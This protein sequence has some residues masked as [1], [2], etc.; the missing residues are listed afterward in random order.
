MSRK[1]ESIFKRSDGRYEGR[2]IKA[3]NNG[4]AVYGYVY[5][6]TYSEC[7]R[8]KNRLLEENKIIKPIQVNKIKGYKTLNDL[9]IKWLSSKNNI[10]QSSYT[11]YYNLINQH[12]KYDIGN[13][14]INKINSEVIN[15]Y[16]QSKL[17]NG[18]IDNAG[19][20]SRNTVYDICNILKQ[21]FKENNIQIDM[22][23]VSKKV[24]TGKSLYQNE[25]ELLID[26]LENIDNS[27]TIGILLSILLGIRESEVCGIR[28]E[29]IDI[30]NKVI[31]INRIVSRVKTFESKRKTKLILS[32]PKT[33]NSIRILPIP[34]RL[35]K[36]LSYLK[37]DL[38]SNCYLLTKKEKYMDPRTFYNHYKRFVKKLNLNYTFHDL[39]HTFA[40]NCID[41]GIDYK[42]LMELL[43]H[44]NITTTM[45][46][47]VHP[48]IFSKRNY[49]NKL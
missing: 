15:N 33:E 28:L 44:S 5:A 20:L 24:G 37:S 34:E 48:T 43:G 29:D 6:K 36:S 38:S 40:T 7:K 32:T 31:Y 12:I 4:K 47:Y 39:R 16:I 11:R 1:G 8:K 41:I 27:I 49:V 21:V 10:K 30:S 2:Y 42:T 45:N 18:R 9:V 22:I 14:K 19:G 13:L 35:I 46:I 3:Y 25:K 23:K 26:Y 17:D